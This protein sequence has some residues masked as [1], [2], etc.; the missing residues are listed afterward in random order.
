MH[1][2]K[3]CVVCGGEATYKKHTHEEDAGGIKVSINHVMAFVCAAC[4]EMEMS[5]RLLA[6]LQRQ[7][8]CLAL[9]DIPTA[10]G[11]MLRYARKSV[12][13]RQVD[14]AKLL[15][16]A[17]ET[18]SRMENDAHPIDRTMKM[19]VIGVLQLFECG[20]SAAEVLANATKPQPTSPVEL[21]AEAAHSSRAA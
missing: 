4:G 19:A 12:G 6:Q 20:A 18:I 9:S 8:A 10:N 2:K 15:G 7:A 16:I 11:A 14:L 21:V 13:L 3:P 5:T 17:S 1:T